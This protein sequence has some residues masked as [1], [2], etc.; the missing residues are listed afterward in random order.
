M[1]DERTAQRAALEL[2]ASMLQTGASIAPG[3]IPGAPGIL[4]PAL[5]FLAELVRTAEVLIRDHGMTPEEIIAAMKMP[6]KL[7]VDGTRRD[8]DERVRELPEKG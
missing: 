5:S 1:T 7:A 3:L 8:I 6:R 2:A 4:G